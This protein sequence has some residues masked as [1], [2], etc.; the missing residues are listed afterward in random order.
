MTMMIDVK[1]QF[2]PSLLLSVEGWKLTKIPQQVG[3]LC[4]R[5]PEFAALYFSKDYLDHKALFGTT[6]Y[7]KL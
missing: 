6:V 7:L 1:Y 5:D 3:M 2:R 4:M